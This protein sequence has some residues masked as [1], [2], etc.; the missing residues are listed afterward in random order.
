ME[1]I[2]VGNDDLAVRG[3]LQVTLQGIHAE[4]DGVFHRRDGVFRHQAGAAAVGLE[5]NG[6][7]A[8]AGNGKQDRKHEKEHGFFH[9]VT[10][11]VLPKDR[12]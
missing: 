12:K 3:D 10:W 6:V 9:D 5:V 11:L 2:L 8:A 7:L 4:V 1:I